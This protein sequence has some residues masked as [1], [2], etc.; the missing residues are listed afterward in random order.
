MSIG[1]YKPGQGYW[2]RMM[3]AIGAGVLIGAG[4]SYVWDELSSVDVAFERVYLQGGVA[5]VIV[6][7]GAVF[8]Y[9][10][11]Y[12]APRTSEFLISTEGEMKKVNWSTR[13]EIIG[14]TWVVIAVAFS[15]AAILFVVDIGFSTLFTKVG[16]LDA[17]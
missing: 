7:V 15:I 16:L 10:F 8:I 11:V 3:S 14:S 2:T 6:F 13:K 5:A 4:A 17:G 12:S 1:V 9:R